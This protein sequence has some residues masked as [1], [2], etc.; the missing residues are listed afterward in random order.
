MRSIVQMLPRWI[1]RRD[2][3]VGQTALPFLAV[4]GMLFFQVWIVVAFGDLALA[5]LAVI[6][7]LLFTLII[8]WGVV[9]NLPTYLLLINL[10]PLLYLN[11]TLHYSFSWTL[12]QDIPL[13]FLIALAIAEFIRKR[14]QGRIRGL[15]IN[16]PLILFFF[17]FFISAAIGFFR[18][19]PLVHVADELYHLS[20]Y[21][22]SIFILYLLRDR[23]DYG[24]LF[25]F[26]I[27][28]SASIS[29]VYIYYFFWEGVPQIVTFQADLFPMV[30]AML[31]AYA[32]TAKQ[33]NA[34]R[35]IAIA[36]L[37]PVAAALVASLTR[38][39]WVSTF[40]A[41][42][43]VT[44][45]HFRK[46]R[47]LSYNKIL[48]ILVVSIPFLFMNNGK[49]SREPVSTSRGVENRAQSISNPGADASFLMRVEIG[50][51][52]V[53][54]FM[55]SPLVGKGLGDHV[56]YKILSSLRAEIFYPDNSWI[57]FLWKGGLLGLAL[58]VWMYSRLL[59]HIHFLYNRSDRI[60]VQA[61]TLG[62]LGGIIALLFDGLFCATLMKYKY[63][64]VFGIIFAYVEFERGQIQRNG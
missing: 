30:M 15:E 8:F 14:S 51:Y 26:V 18:G 37:F 16:T 28:I 62:L 27:L 48:I 17:Y 23:R 10:A 57:F 29:A 38:A 44:F 11:E 21:V 36:L 25:G 39:L 6:D 63:G 3:I 12:V 52:A 56:N 42:G 34:S 50:Y 46:N 47:T 24:L 58:A 9:K 40:L 13:F 49:T 20:Y 32:L 53:Q 31:Y 1:I 59:K 7:L 41:M 35:W 55:Q 22:V 45:F 19:F 64:I 60:K 61:L 54:K 2:L 33:W 43:A 5:L 4:G